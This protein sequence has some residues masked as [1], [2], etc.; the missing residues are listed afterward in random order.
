MGKFLL[1]ENLQIMYSQELK[2]W[3]T[4]AF[5]LWQSKSIP[6]M[7]HS[8]IMLQISLLHRRDQALLMI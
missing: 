8:V 7:P 3:D 6:T 2:M 1:I 4:I 5:S